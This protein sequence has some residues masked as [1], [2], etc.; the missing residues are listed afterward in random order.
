MTH[1]NQNRSR[2]GPHGG[3][4]VLIVGLL[5]VASAAQADIPN[6]VCMSCHDDMED[7]FAKTPHGVYLSGHPTLAD[8][9]CESCHGAGN[10][11]V[12]T[13]GDPD[14][15]INPAGQDQFDTQVLCLTCHSGHQFDDWAFSS[16]NA[17][18]VGCASC[19]VVHGEAGHSFKA[20]PPDLCYTCHSDVRAAAH[21]PSHHPIGEGKLSC[22]D[23]HGAHGE[24]PT[25]VMDGSG[26]ELC[27]S[28]H[29]AK[30]GPFVYEHAPATEDCKICHV[31]H[32]SV[33]DNL[34]VQAEPALCLNCHPMHFHAA[35]EGWDGSF[36]TPQTPERAGEST[37]EGWKIAMLTKCTQCHTAMHGT[38]LPSQ[39]I[40]SGG[41]A[42]TR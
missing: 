36:G 5:L 21:M 12:E 31:P 2:G 9:S 28:C 14:A 23:C 39:T 42:L 26:N 32:G 7:S 4:V 37:P 18:G 6:D 33:A 8:N 13:E 24:T 25:L 10:A 40:S 41:N 1:Y 3:W 38:D 16:H 20:E 34:L 19:H 22:Q 27:Y 29:A 15:I 11:H 17:A 30:E 35:I